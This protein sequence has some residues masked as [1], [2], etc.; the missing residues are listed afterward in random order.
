LRENNLQSISN[1][2]HGVKVIRIL[3][4]AKR[5]LIIND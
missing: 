1:G 5:K 3:D 2:D 4:D